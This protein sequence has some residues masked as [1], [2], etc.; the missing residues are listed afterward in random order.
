MAG[1]TPQNR[2]NKGTNRLG[3]VVSRKLRA[4]GWN[5]SPAARRHR[6]DGIYVS[7]QDNHVSIVLDLGLP[8]RNTQVMLKMAQELAAWPGTSEEIRLSSPEGTDA[9]FIHFTYNRP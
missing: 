7:A 2:G 3:A 1:Y 9:C 5:I 4:A 8:Q 6:H